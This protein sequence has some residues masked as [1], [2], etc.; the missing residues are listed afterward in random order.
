MAELGHHPTRRWA[1]GQAAKKPLCLCPYD[2]LGR[3]SMA[4]QDFM[5]RE[6]VVSG[7]RR[8]IEQYELERAKAYRQVQW[9]VPVFLGAVIVVALLLAIAFNSFAS[10]YEQWVSAP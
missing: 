2:R 8:D 6:D 10:P 5:P 3:A 9:R 7:I 1:S 4:P